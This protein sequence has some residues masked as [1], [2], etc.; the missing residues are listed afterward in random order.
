MVGYVQGNDMRQKGIKS[1]TD[2]RNKVGNHTHLKLCV[3][4]W[5]L[6]QLNTLRRKAAI[7]NAHKPGAQGKRST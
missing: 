7:L 4:V 2:E 3:C 5:L 6:K 1:R